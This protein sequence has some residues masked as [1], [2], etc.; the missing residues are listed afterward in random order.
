MYL[1]GEPIQARVTF[2]NSEMTNKTNSSTGQVIFT[3]PSVAIGD[4]KYFVNASI[5]GDLNASYSILVKNKTKILQIDFP[6][7]YVDEMIK[8]NITI[9]SRC[10]PI[11]GACIWFDSSKYTSNKQ[12]IV[13]LTAPDVLVSTNYGIIVN[14]T[15]YISNSTVLTV[16]EKDVGN[17]LMEV[18]YP[19]I[20]ESG[21][22]KTKIHVIDK[23]GG[24]ANVTIYSYYENNK[25]SQYTTDS[26]GTAEI[27]IPLINNNNYFSL[28]VEKNGY[29]IYDDTEIVI[30]FFAKNLDNNL[31]ILVNPS[32]VYEGNV[33]TTVVTDELGNGISGTDIWRGSYKVQ[34]TTDSNGIIEIIAPSVFFDREYYLYAIKKGYNFAEKKITVR[35]II[36]QQKKLVIEFNKSVN[37]SDIFYIVTKDEN[38]NLIDGTNVLFDSQQKLTD[39]S[40]IVYFL[41][42]NVT[43]DMF[44]SINANKYGY[45]PLSSSIEIIDVEAIYSNGETNKK[46]KI[47]AAPIVLENQEF[48]VTVRDENDNLLTDVCVTFMDNSQYTD[49]TGTV[50]FNAPDVSWDRINKI[51]VVKP[52]YESSTFEI[53][54]KNNEEFEYLHLIIIIFI[55]LII[56][57]IYYIKYRKI[58]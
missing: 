28:A 12:G 7:N 42:P 17:R 18:I 6:Y 56:G 44:Y 21:S 36:A 43:T 8:F 41:A 57:I 46:I 51:L 29:K 14:K 10:E 55:V 30:N 25:F 27:Q 16:L 47:C 13:T 1:D 20:I 58:V 50:I 19:F 49:F 35:N 26:N 5:P 11:E 48:T 9:Y 33:L 53:T 37:E 3:M 23:Y 2:G 45:Y 40:G 15:G 32:E 24:L 4:K 52:G 34:G 31:E 39:K 54:I 22:E 38:G